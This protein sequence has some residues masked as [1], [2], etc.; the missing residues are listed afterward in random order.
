MVTVKTPANTAKAVCRAILI[1]LV[2]ALTA[3]IIT[4]CIGCE[5]TTPSRE[6]V[7]ADLAWALRIAYDVGGKAAVSNRI[8]QLVA[9]GKL[10]REQADALHEAAQRAYEKIIDDLDPAAS[11]NALQGV[12][13]A[14]GCEG[15]GCTLEASARATG[16]SGADCGNC[17]ED[18]C[19]E[20][21]GYNEDAYCGE[22]EDCKAQ[23]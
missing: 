8:E 6:A 20:A 3:G 10:T 7:R 2:A 9:K 18:G 12:S 14:S 5:T 21:G 19:S 17:G 22:C 13:G 15:D 16:D 23:R 11:T 4:C 1:V